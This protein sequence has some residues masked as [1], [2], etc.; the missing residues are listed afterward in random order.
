MKS[1][2]KPDL[3]LIRGD[4]AQ[5]PDAIIMLF[6]RLMGRKA[7]DQEIAEAKAWKPK[8]SKPPQR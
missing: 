2:P 8:E 1:K 5:E 7:T 3:T 4:K 6:E